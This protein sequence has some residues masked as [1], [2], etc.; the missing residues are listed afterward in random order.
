MNVWI[1][2]GVAVAWLGT[3]VYTTVRT[4]LAARDGEALEWARHI[5]R[6]RI[7]KEVLALPGVN[8]VERDAVV[9]VIR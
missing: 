3:C 4:L 1:L 7:L 6:E 8:L 9:R 5:E 2:S